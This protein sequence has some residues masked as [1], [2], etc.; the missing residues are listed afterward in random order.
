MSRNY[1]GIKALISGLF[2]DL[3]LETYFEA[4]ALHNMWVPVKI[5]ITQEMTEIWEKYMAAK[6]TCVAEMHSRNIWQKTKKNHG[7]G[8]N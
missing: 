5:C 7:F 2:L 6:N 8:K 4:Q 3:Q 1:W